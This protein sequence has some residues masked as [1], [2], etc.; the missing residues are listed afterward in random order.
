MCL[1]ICLGELDR[2]ELVVGTREYGVY[3]GQNPCY[4]GGQE[5]GIQVCEQKLDSHLF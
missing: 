3:T 5:Q 1:A 2:E 4:C